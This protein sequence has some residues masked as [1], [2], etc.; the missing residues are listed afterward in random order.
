MNSAPN[1]LQTL[2]GP[3]SWI[4]LA[5]AGVIGLV[6]LVSPKTF[7]SLAEFGGRGL[8]SDKWL[9]QLDKRIDVDRLVLPYSRWLGAAVITAVAILCFRFSIH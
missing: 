4:L 2:W 5:L 9:A 6:A 8:D 3:C 7:R 1:L